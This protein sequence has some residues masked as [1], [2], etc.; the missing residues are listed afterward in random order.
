MVGKTSRVAVRGCNV[1]QNNAA[2]GISIGGGEADV[3]ETLQVLN[4]VIG[5]R[6]G[7]GGTLRVNGPVVIQGNS[8]SGIRL[9]GSFANIGG[10]PADLN[11]QPIITQN[12]STA[13]VPGLN[14]TPSFTPAGINTEGNSHLELFAARV[15]NNPGAGVV[16][17]NNASARFGADTITNNNGGGVLVTNLSTAALFSP[18]PGF[19]ANNITGNSGVDLS[20]TP[21]SFAFGDKSGIGKLTCPRFNVQRL[22]GP[23]PDAEKPGKEK[24]ESE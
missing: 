18:S 14:N 4:N 22:P 2:V 7:G 21:D 6:S 17:S 16:L 11:Q 19:P 3:S 12:G 1:I 23:P 15:T 10:D 5:I 8:L 24:P 13:I 20:C 9:L